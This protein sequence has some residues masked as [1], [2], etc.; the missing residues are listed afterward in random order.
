[1]S[2]RTQLYL[3]ETKLIRRQIT[4]KMDRKLTEP[5]YSSCSV[6]PSLTYYLYS[7]SSLLQTPPP[8]TELGFSTRRRLVK[9]RGQLSCEVRGL[10]KI[11]SIIIK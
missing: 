8:D 10:E 4:R 6:S 5:C 2:K 3:L 1:M 7:L 11:I 9:E